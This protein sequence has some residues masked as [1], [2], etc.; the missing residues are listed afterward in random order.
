MFKV[1]DIIDGNT[2]EVS[3]Q[4]KW[5]DKIGNVVKVLGYPTPDEQT[6]PFVKNKLSTLILNKDIDLKNPTTINI[7]NQILAYVYLNGIN[8]ASYFP[9]LKSVV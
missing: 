1:T 7:N 9:E 6:T 3:P 8:I 2:I 5:N 4:W